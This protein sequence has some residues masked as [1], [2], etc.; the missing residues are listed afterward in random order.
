MQSAPPVTKRIADIEMRSVHTCATMHTV[1]RDDTE[2]SAKRRASGI[3]SATAAFFFFF[4][5]ATGRQNAPVLRVYPGRANVPRVS[6]GGKISS[7]HLNIST[8]FSQ[9]ILIIGHD[10]SQNSS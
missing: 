10:I 1:L 7:M 9:L 6:I 2:T 4:C 8:C 5:V 3:K